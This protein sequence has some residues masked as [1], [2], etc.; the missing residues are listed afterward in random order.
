MPDLKT[1]RVPE[2]TQQIKFEVIIPI[3]E[4]IITPTNIVFRSYTQNTFTPDGK[5]HVHVKFNNISIIDDLYVLPDGCTALIGR[6]WIRRLGINLNELDNGNS[7]MFVTNSI[8][9]SNQIEDLM[10]EFASVFDQKIGCI[11]NYKISLQL[12]ENSTH[13]YTKERQIPYA[14]T[15]RVNKELDELEKGGII[16]NVAN[17]DRGSPLVVIPKADGGVRLCVDYKVGVNQRLVSAHYP[18]RKIDQIFN[19]LKD[20]KY[21]CRLDLY[22]AYLHVPVDDLSSEIQTISTHRGTFRMK[23]VS[24]VIWHQNSS[25]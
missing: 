16:T 1:L 3:T 15:E 11:P 23:H 2:A 20:S 7:A 19:S 8:T 5:V 10:A 17:S 18:I 25:C 12:R 9:D 13:S 24:P 21:Y 4:F 14:L 22:K 6:T